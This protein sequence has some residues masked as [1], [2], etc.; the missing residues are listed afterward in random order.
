MLKIMKG[1]EDKGEIV[2]FESHKKK[3]NSKR[4]LLWFMLISLLMHAL[5]IFLFSSY[6]FQSNSFAKLKELFK[7]KKEE[8]TVVIMFHD[9]HK[10]PE[11]VEQTQKQEEQT[12]SSEETKEISQ[13]QPLPTPIINTTPAKLTAPLSPFGYPDAQAEAVHHPEIP[14]A[15]DG[16]IEQVTSA[17]IVQPKTEQTPPKKVQTPPQ[18]NEKKI[19]KVPPVHQACKEKFVPEKKI[20]E[21]ALA[22]SIDTSIQ[23]PSKLMDRIREVEKEKTELQKSFLPKDQKLIQV[24]SELD[25]TGPEVKVRGAR[26]EEPS[27]APKKNIIALT[28]GFV[29]KLTGEHGTDLIDRDGDPNKRPSFEELKFLG[30]EAKI[31]WALQASWKQNFEYNTQRKA[32]PGKVD[33]AFVIDAQGNPHN[34]TIVQSSGKQELDKTIINN[35]RNAAPYP[36]IP[37]H[38]N[39]VEYP[40][41]RSIHV[42][43]YGRGF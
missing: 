12:P 26:K 23:A 25:I 31:N 22:A 32:I 38:L 19:E 41:R 10:E 43:L 9:E 37:A 4:Y 18:K 30:Y 39:M 15:P 7:S 16:L 1:S 2:L 28:K 35:I 17:P 5:L 29:E 34:I 40:V 3:N 24:H 8:K 11:P 21:S 20:F 14:E 27:A 6:G 42:Y 36:P 33:V 13:A